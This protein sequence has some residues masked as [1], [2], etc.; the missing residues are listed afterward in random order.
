MVEEIIGKY[1]GFRE[2]GEHYFVTIK[3]AQKDLTFNFNKDPGTARILQKLRNGQKVGILRLQDKCVLRLPRDPSIALDHYNMPFESSSTTQANDGLNKK[4]NLAHNDIKIFEEELLSIPLNNVGS[5]DFNVYCPVCGQAYPLTRENFYYRER[6][7]YNEKQTLYIKC[8]KCVERYN[9]TKTGA[10]GILSLDP[11]FG[12]NVN[13]D[14]I[15]LML[16]E[17]AD[18]KKLENIR[19]DLE[20]KRKERVGR[21]EIISKKTLLLATFR[22][23]PIF[24]RY[25]LD[26]CKPKKIDRMMVVDSYNFTRTRYYLEIFDDIGWVVRK[27]YTQHTITIMIGAYTKAIFGFGFG[28][29][30]Y[31]ATRSCGLMAMNYTSGYLQKCLVKFDGSDDEKK[32]LLDVGVQNENLNSVPKS[33]CRTFINQCEGIIKVLRSKGLGKRLYSLPVSIFMRSAVAFISWNL[34]QEHVLFDGRWH[35]KLSELLQIDA[36][37]DW[38]S[39]LE[40]SWR[41]ILSDEVLYKTYYPKFNRGPKKVNDILHKGFLQPQ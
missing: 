12:L 7:G 23:A 36:P 21:R 20:T 6:K 9:K 13:I 15:A 25:V 31:E 39:L 41:Y 33:V 4:P 37:A 19:K 22:S 14:E 32:A 8:K 27:G 30:E 40:L 28:E 29:N 3:A 5:L 16:E 26:C 24:F 11:F 38:K 17:M 2:H 10:I 34:F 35:G 18:G 1:I